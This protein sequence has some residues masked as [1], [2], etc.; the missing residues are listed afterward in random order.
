M[1]KPAAIR[2][3]IALLVAV[4]SWGFAAEPVDPTVAAVLKTY[5]I[6]CHGGDK[7]KADLALDKLTPDFARNAEPWKVV[8]DRL[9]DGSMSPKG[10]PRPT[11]SEFLI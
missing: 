6:S 10:K 4:P 9:S 11:A 2:A 8:H 7:P 5:C 1:T 3:A